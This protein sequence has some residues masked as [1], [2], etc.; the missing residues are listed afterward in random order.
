[1]H[2]K[3]HFCIGCTSGFHSHYHRLYMMIDAIKHESVMQ[4]ITLYIAFL[5]YVKV[6]ERTKLAN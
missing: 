4:V 5:Q 1:M 3:K 6:C 2:F